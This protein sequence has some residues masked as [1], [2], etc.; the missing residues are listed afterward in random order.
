[1][2]QGNSESGYIF[3]IDKPYRWT[4]FDVVKKIR[5]TIKIK[6][7]GHA[8]TLDPLATGLLIICAGKKT[9]SIESFMG[10]AKS[11]SGTFRLGA[12]TPSYDLE[13][14]IDQEVTLEGVTDQMINTALAKFHGEI[15]QKPPIYSA[16]KKDGKRLYLHAREGREVEIQA[17]RVT[18]Y[19]FFITSIQLPDVHFR[20]HCSKGTYVRSLARD[21]GEE[22]G[23][24]AHLTSLR[25]EAIGAF[26]VSNATNMEELEH[27]WS[28]YED[29]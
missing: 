12:S 1:M 19:D 6:K 15:W 27:K 5:N 28:T 20:L 21:L 3:L 25:R 7:T 2:I 13:T 11:Y 9:K 18:I 8:G 22:L 24:L 10:M 26:N 17:R 29:S 14:E 16:I 23:S 4:S